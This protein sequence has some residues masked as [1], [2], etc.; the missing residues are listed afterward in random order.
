MCHGSPNFSPRVSGLA[1]SN[2]VLMSKL[3]KHIVGRAKLP[4]VFAADSSSSLASAGNLSRWFLPR[5]MSSSSQVL[6]L[7]PDAK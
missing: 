4:C 6:F 3:A 7:V 2:A 5:V 1:S